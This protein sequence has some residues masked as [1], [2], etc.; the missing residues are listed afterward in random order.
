MKYQITFDKARTDV[1]LGLFKEQ[2]ERAANMY[3]ATFEITRLYLHEQEQVF[4]AH[5]GPGGAWAPLTAGS[6]S[7]KAR[8]GFPEVMVKSGMLRG[9]LTQ[10]RGALGAA[11]MA[12]K[13]SAIMGTRAPHA[14][15]QALGTKERV[16]KTTGRATG[17]VPAREMGKLNAPLV[18]RFY[19]VL[20]NYLETG[21][22]ASG[23]FGGGLGL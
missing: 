7:T 6:L 15:L 9:S 13:T 11:T 1:L 22:V 10:R 12:T 8:G 17:R 14:H 16:Q 20:G 2:A 18:A 21:S 5:G 4:A 19:N 3:P 23:S